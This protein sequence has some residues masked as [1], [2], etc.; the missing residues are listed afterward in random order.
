ML[1]I[2]W[3]R[4][5]CANCRKLNWFMAEIW[6]LIVRFLRR[7]MKLI[8]QMDDGAVI[9]D[10]EVI[11]H[12]S[13]SVSVPILRNTFKTETL[14][15]VTRLRGLW[16]VSRAQRWGASE[17]RCGIMFIVRLQ[18]LSTHN[19]T[20]QKDKIKKTLKKYSHCKTSLEIDNNKGVT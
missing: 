18:V 17:G 9:S 7:L 1:N 14:I 12:A 10:F 5:F 3:I 20:V 4:K 11:R 2:K 13:D 16:H 8:H 15:E 6:E 19:I